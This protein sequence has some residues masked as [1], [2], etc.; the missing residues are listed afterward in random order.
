MNTKHPHIKFTFKHEHNT[1]FLFLS[2]KVSCENN[3]FTISV[4]GK[5]TFSGVLTNFKSFKPTVY[6]F[7]LVNTLLYCCF[8]IA[9]SYDKFHNEIDGQK[10]IFQLNRYPI[11]FFDSA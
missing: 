9:S 1:F 6:K 7:G 5:P 10:Q 4:Y 11:Q 3:K 2:V 8:N